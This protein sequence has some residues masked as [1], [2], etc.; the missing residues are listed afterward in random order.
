M[1]RAIGARRLAASMLVLWVLFGFTGGALAHASLIRST[2]GDGGMV[3]EAPARF[4]LTFNE[5]V[6][7]L[8]LKL[9]TPGGEA[10]SLSGVAQQGETLSIDAPPSLGNGTYALSWRVVSGDGHPIGGAVVFSIGAPSAGPLPDV[11]GTVDWPVRIALWTAKLMLY[12][13]LFAGAGGAFFISWIGGA[14]KRASGSLMALGLAAAAASVGLQGVDALD[15]SLGGLSHF[16]VWRAGFATS[17]GSTAGIAACALIAGL[18]ALGLR[19]DAA[20]ALSLLALVGTGAALAASGHAGA[21]SPQWLTRPA[22]FLHAAGIAFWAGAL[23]PLGLALAAP[24]GALAAPRGAAEAMLNRFSRIAPFAVLPLM[25]AGIVLAIVQIRSVQALWTTAYGNVFLIKLALLILLFALAALNRFRLTRPA[26]DGDAAA[27]RMLR[28]SIFAELLLFLAIFGVAASWRFTPPPRVLAEAA[29]EPAAIHLHTEKAMADLTLTP[30][31]VGAVGASM[32]I[33]TG[34][35][36]P[37]P[38]KEVTL[39]LANP[40]AGIEPITRPATQ[41]GDG[42]W[43]VRNLPVPAPGRWSVRIDILISDFE[44][45]RLEGSIDIRR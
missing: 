18:I 16:A 41:P 28:R 42:T 15:A 26:A 44:L 36:G 20:K 35:F 24:R 19:G 32:I 3:A 29:A 6:S 31:R 14:G 30:G 12:A 11:A 1:I 13:G 37:L 5:P 43:Q 33:M 22:V 45:A 27:C 38:A 9:V 10:I 7:P 39:T 8:V 40:A 4:T 21:A 2:P 34:D 25:A 17:Y 23:M